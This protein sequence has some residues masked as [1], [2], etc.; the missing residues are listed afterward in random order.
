[1]V[2]NGFQEVAHTR[3]TPSHDWIKILYYFDVI[4]M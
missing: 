3:N 2:K 4:N 1:M